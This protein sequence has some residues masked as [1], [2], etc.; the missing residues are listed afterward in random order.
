MLQ[1]EYMT[2]EC[3]RTD[4]GGSTA[5]RISW[6]TQEAYDLPPS[7]EPLVA[8]NSV[9]H[10]GWELVGSEILRTDIHYAD[11][12]VAHGSSRGIRYLFKRPRGADDALL[13]AEAMETVLAPETAG[14]A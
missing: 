1:W 11:L 3:T 8:M 12:S 4:D 9:G 6:P 7:T 5:I 13:V 2:M 10:L 14:P